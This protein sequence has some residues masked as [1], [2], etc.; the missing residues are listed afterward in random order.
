MCKNIAFCI[1]FLISFLFSYILSGGFHDYIKKYHKDAALGMIQS[2]ALYSLLRS[3]ISVEG[4]DQACYSPEFFHVND[5]NQ[6]SVRLRPD[7]QKH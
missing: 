7:L 1:F 5:T 6:S 3:P 2:D 4:F